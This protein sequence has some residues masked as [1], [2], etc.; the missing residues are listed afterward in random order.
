MKYNPHWFITHYFKRTAH[1]QPPIILDRTHMFENGGIMVFLEWMAQKDVTY[2][3]SVTP[4]V[5][6]TQIS[7]T[8]AELR[9][10]YNTSYNV[11]ISATLCGQNSTYTGL[12]IYFGESLSNKINMYIFDY[13]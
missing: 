13:S 9:V 7:G 8:S 10:A 5:P 12:E 4:K 3:I 1:L 2:N 11:I 6:T